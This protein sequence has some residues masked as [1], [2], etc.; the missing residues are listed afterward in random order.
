MTRKL[1]P[2]FAD[3]EPWADEWA[4]PTET[5]RYTKRCTDPFEKTQAFY[6]AIFPRGE[7]IL[8]YLDTCSLDD[9]S[10]EALNLLRL[11]YSL[12]CV[13]VSVEAWR[14]GPI[15]DTGAAEMICLVEPTP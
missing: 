13:S 6:D 11:M 3:L 9:L 12:V 15:P 5:E 8:A 4:L 14:Q 1:P 10:D 7:A 2:E